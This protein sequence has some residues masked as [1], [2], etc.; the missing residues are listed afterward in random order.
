MNLKINENIKNNDDIEDILDT[1]LEKNTEEKDDLD[2]LMNDFDELMSDLNSGNTSEDIVSLSNEEIKNMG[3]KKKHPLLILFLIV[4]WSLVFILWNPM[5]NDE[6][7]YCKR[8]ITTKFKTELNMSSLNDVKLLNESSF[9]ETN[10]QRFPNGNTV[11][12]VLNVTDENQKY[13]LV[14][15]T[16]NEIIKEDDPLYIGLKDFFDQFNFVHNSEE[17]MI[18]KEFI[19]D[20]NVFPDYLMEPNKNLA[21]A[22]KFDGFK[23]RGVYELE[24][25]IMYDSFKDFYLNPNLF[26]IKQFSY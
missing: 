13:V 17:V 8:F 14:F 7:A 10:N 6:L 23:E 22:I 20:T 24:L 19:Y 3:I 4:F 1:D 5:K 21:F 26:T 25:G 15:E 2:E 18:N 12:Y 9:I 16:N 11:N